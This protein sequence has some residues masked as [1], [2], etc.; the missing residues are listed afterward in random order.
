MKQLPVAALEMRS[1]VTQD[2]RLCLSLDPVS[3]DDPARG[4]VIVRVEG[5]PVNPSDLGTLLCTVSPADLRAEASGEPPALSAPLDS[6]RFAKLSGRVGQSLTVG[7]EGMGRVVAA[8]P[9]VTDM[10]GKTVA[11]FG[12][13]MYA[14]YRRIAADAC[15]ILPDGTTPET[16][17]GSFVNP[18][19]ALS[20]VEAMRREGHSALVHTAAASNLGQML[21]RICSADGVDLVNIVRSPD[22]VRLL[23]ALGA[24]HV[25]DSS[26]PD[27]PAQL[28]EAIGSSGA[29]IAFDAV[30]GGNLA[31][32]ILTAME[33][34]AGRS[35]QPYSRYG[36]NK[37]KQVYIY[38]GFDPS[39]LV[40]EK[41]FG[42]AWGVGGWLLGTFL[43]RIGEARVAELKARIARELTTTFA[44]T[45][46]RSV[47]LTELLQP[48][49]L[50]FAVARSTGSKLLVKPN[51]S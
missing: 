24:S 45:Y 16:G 22:Q 7:L 36:S 23:K 11:M 12:G 46:N 9:D 43:D 8:G 3:I 18:L 17:A 29:T 34:A 27:F 31:S 28:E 37:S 33:K 51:G 5:A 41:T 26:A 47:S 15:M 20:M 32:M 14:Q 25:C 40:L 4:E 30:G 6:V 50:A 48:E 2:A 13:G 42:M 39:P 49:T 38:G 19:T 21:Q 10:I 35:A 1:L 44:S